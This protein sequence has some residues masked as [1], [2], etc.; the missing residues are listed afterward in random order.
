MTNVRLSLCSRDPFL[1]VYLT[2]LSSVRQQ[3]TYRRLST[4]CLTRKILGDYKCWR[5]NWQMAPKVISPLFLKIK[6]S[7]YEISLLDPDELV[8][9]A[10]IRRQIVHGLKREH[11]IFVT[12]IQGW[13]RQPSLEE[14]RIICHPKKHLL[15]KWLGCL[16]M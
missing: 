1:M 15:I 14:L 16:W 8:S 7:C 11:T 10:R 3:M 12:P 5:M 4:G 6:N 13:D 9:K 2:M